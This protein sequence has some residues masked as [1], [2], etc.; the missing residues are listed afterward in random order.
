LKIRLTLRKHGVI[1]PTRFVSS[2]RRSGVAL[3]SI[4]AVMS[5]PLS[6][7]TRHV[8]EAIVE[9]INLIN[10]IMSTEGRTPWTGCL[11]FEGVDVDPKAGTTT[12]SPP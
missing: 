4:W 7:K 5:L 3:G 10:G 12:R 11:V 9:A 6:F 1:E 2:G 8:S